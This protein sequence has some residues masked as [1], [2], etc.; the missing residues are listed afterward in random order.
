MSEIVQK[1]ALVRGRIERAQER[2]P[3]HQAVTLVAVTKFH[4]LAAMEEV[5]SLGVTDVGENRVQEMEEKFR[6]A[7][8]SVR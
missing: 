7:H 1:L 2:S 8:F 6:E 5:V 4:P 3:Y